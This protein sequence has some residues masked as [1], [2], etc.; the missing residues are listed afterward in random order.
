[1]TEPH[2]RK[3]DEPVLLVLK[4]QPPWVFIDEIRRFVQ[5]FVFCACP[6]E[7]REEQLAL[8]VHEM[9]QNAAPRAGRDQ[10]ELVLEVLPDKDQVTISVSNP[11][12]DQEYAVLCDRLAAMNREQDPLAHYLRTMREVPRDVRGGLG[13]AR[14]RFESQLELSAHR[15]G[16]RV[17]VV[18]RGKLRPT[19]IKVPGSVHG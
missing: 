11:C 18:A 9:M 2:I 1:M 12:T 16:N 6:G 4:M 10:V 3:P 5:A 8:A 15:D 14:I 7:G 17:T 13:L 19:Q